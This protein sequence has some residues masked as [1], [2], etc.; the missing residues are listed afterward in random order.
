MLKKEVKYII[1]TSPNCPRCL[2]QKE[3]WNDE[4][5]IYEERDSDRIKNHQD[6]FDRD[7]LIEA[8]M[9]NLELPTILKLK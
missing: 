2:V 1:Y 7:A 6:E 4:G 9:N 3:K 5:I 8:S